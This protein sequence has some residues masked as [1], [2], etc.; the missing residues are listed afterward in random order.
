LGVGLG[1]GLCFAAALIAFLSKRSFDYYNALAVETQGTVSH[2][3]T[4][5]QGD[6]HI[7]TSQY[8]NN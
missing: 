6:N 1:V 8:N 5:V 2:N 3:P 4:H 7:D